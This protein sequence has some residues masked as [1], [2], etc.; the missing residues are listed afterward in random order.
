MVEDLMEYGLLEPQPF[1]SEVHFAS[2]MERQVALARLPH[3]IKDRIYRQIAVVLRK[4]MKT[5]NERQTLSP[6]R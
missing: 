5:K 6:G 4:R 3:K 2:E 1:G